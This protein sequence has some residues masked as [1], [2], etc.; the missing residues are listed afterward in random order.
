M[1]TITSCSTTVAHSR[2]L[3]QSAPTTASS[4]LLPADAT[5]SAPGP[6]TPVDCEHHA[7]PLS[8]LGPHADAEPARVSFRVPS[9][10][11]QLIYQ[12]L[13]C[14]HGF[15]GCEGYRAQSYLMTIKFKAP[16]VLIRDPGR[17]AA[18]GI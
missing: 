8:A 17:H 7:C 10:A 14:T 9:P 16:L 1:D 4:L 13:S 3:A 2:A 6:R 5:P 11:P 12:T 15:S 18:L